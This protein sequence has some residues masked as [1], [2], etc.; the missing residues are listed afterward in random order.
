MLGR[1]CVSSPSPSCASCLPA[2]GHRGG[3]SEVD[4]FSGTSDF[5]SCFCIWMT[6]SLVRIQPEELKDITSPVTAKEMAELSTL[7]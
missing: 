3:N 2:Q 1:G 5:K 6:D 7:S 4:S